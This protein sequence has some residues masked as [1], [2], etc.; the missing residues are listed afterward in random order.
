MYQREA[1]W[2]EVKNI[3]AH[4]P[5]KLHSSGPSSPLFDLLEVSD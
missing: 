3:V 5:D 4:R 2:W 1:L